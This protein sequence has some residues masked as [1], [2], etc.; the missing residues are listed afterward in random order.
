MQKA[1]GKVVLRP[2]GR[3]ELFSVALNISEERR[4]SMW[5]VR[6]ER[7]RDEVGRGPDH[8]GSC[9]LQAINAHVLEQ[10]QH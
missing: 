8:I 3:C 2:C 6:R 7:L 4:K 5:L 10:P 1:E 9:R